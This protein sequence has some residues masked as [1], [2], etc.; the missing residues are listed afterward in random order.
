LR[1]VTDALALSQFTVRHEIE[2]V[3]IFGKPDGRVY[4]DAV[5]SEGGEADITLAVDFNGDGCHEDIV[6]CAKGYTGANGYCSEIPVA[7]VDGL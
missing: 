6:K 7:P 3:V 4:G 1:V 5:L 2:F